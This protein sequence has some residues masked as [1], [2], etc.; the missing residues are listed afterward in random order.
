MHTPVLLYKS[1]VQGGCTL[2]GHVFVMRIIFKIDVNVKARPTTKTRK[3]GFVILS[4][5][6]PK[7]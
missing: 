7:Y 2:H 5:G 6:A 1:G 4:M 3:A